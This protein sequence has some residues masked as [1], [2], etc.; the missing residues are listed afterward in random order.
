MFLRV[1]GLLV[2]LARPALGDQLPRPYVY[3]RDIDATIQ[4]DMRYAAPH[5]F[6]GRVVPGYGAGECILTRPTAEALRRVQRT[7]AP[8]KLSLKAY[9]CYRPVRAVR[10]FEMWAEDMADTK[11]AVEFYPGLDKR[12]LFKLG[13]I[14]RNSTHS[15]GNTV[16]L[17]LVPL[18]S[19][20]PVE[21][22]DAPLQS[23]TAP[24]AGRRADNS[25][26][27]GTGYDCFSA[28]SHTANPEITGEARR[29]RDLLV[30]RMKAA[31]FRNYAKEWWHFDLP[32]AGTEARDFVVRSHERR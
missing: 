5:N 32:G 25:L 29:N 11:M 24:R 28:L 20:V 7:L 16:D 26:D 14:S 15:R 23:C 19:G 13:Y 22:G 10:A 27:F 17:T 2:A 30:A 6:L 31:G 18:G 12:D 8:L 4:Q 9:D 1:L 3:L 21:T